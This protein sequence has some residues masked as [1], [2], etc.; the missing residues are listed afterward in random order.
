[1]AE[2][3]IVN[4]RR[5]VGGLIGLGVAVPSFLAGR[6]AFGIRQGGGKRWAVLV[7]V[8]KYA[9]VPERP[10]DPKWRPDADDLRGPDN[11][12]PAMRELLIGKYAFDPANIRTLQNE[13]ATRQAILE[14][15]EWLR[16]SAGADDQ[17][18]FYYSGHGTRV[19][20]PKEDRDAGRD[21]YTSAL[22]PHDARK[23]GVLP[24]YE[25]GKRIDALQTPCVVVIVDACS[26]GSASR[27]PFIQRRYL[28]LTSKE[29]DDPFAG[30]KPGTATE[31]MAGTEFSSPAPGKAQR[32]RYLGASRIGQPAV[33][34]ALLPPENANRYMGAMTF[35]LLQELR[36]D[37]QNRLTYAALGEALRTRLLERFQGDASNPQLSGPGIA[38]EPFLNFPR[39]KPAP[40]AAVAA[41]VMSVNGDAVT[42]RSIA[43]ATLA[44]GS[45][46]ET[47]ISA[48]GRAWREDIADSDRALI[49]ITA[50]ASGLATGTVA[51]GKALTGQKLTE[52]LR[53]LASGDGLT[54]FVSGPAMAE[55]KRDA[56]SVSEV[57]LAE[58]PDSAD[59]ALL[60]DSREQIVVYRGA[61]PLPMA[62]LEKLPTLL[63]RL[64][65]IKPLIDLQNPSENLT[66]T[67]TGDGQP[68]FAERRIG[69]KIPYI[70]TANRDG[71]LTIL[72]LAADGKLTGGADI[73][74]A[75]HVPFRD[76]E[77][78][79]TPP[80]GVDILKVL[81]TL[82]PVGVRIPQTGAAFEAQGG[83]AKEIVL[84]IL[85]RFRAA[86]NAD[87][88]RGQ[89]FNLVGV[90]GGAVAVDGWTTADFYLHIL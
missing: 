17:V 23:N 32:E 19:A 62:T 12:V 1:M 79:V 42:L 55:V 21:A 36:R 28:T 56:A 40:T 10:N 35:F 72:A 41:E 69:E 45:L 13:K 24:G 15:W 88:G 11:D 78:T 50:V 4:R 37:T 16:T 52:L 5:F 25:I 83:D 8:A 30:A 34:D 67:V 54:V 7:G 66:L 29:F 22:C 27:S 31:A 18:V 14:A 49:K 73:P 71:Y 59:V 46:L 85:R 58:T 60:A 20:R 84:Q 81:F 63:R 64:A 44:K 76:L 9:P 90:G 61:T 75:A 53:G 33:D 86:V 6:A 74:V 51:K 70:I 39:V 48:G 26:S 38:I 43:G 82:R 65:A 68:V 47:R 80:R 2:T 89:D 3:V 87:S 77:A 57:R